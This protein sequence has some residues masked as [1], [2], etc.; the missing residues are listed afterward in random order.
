RVY[1]PGPA[2]I[3]CAGAKS[4]LGYTEAHG[5][6]DRAM[7][8]DVVQ[9]QA[10]HG[11]VTKILTRGLVRMRGRRLAVEPGWFEPGRPHFECGKPVAIALHRDVLMLPQGKQVLH[12]LRRSLAEAGDHAS[13][14]IEK[15]QLQRSVDDPEPVAYRKPRRGGTPAHFIHQDF[16]GSPGHSI[17]AGVLQIGQK[18]F[19]VAAGEL[20]Q[21]KDLLR[22]ECVDV[23][24]GIAGFEQT[25]QFEIPFERQIGIDAAL[26]ENVAAADSPDLLHL[27]ENF[28]ERESEG[29]LLM[30]GAIESAKPAG[31]DADIRIVN[32]A[33]NRVSGY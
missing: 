27:A 23:N 15:P 28:I 13:P 29:F 32:V 31:H 26:N 19:R 25:E 18:V 2:K 20:L 22:A 21:A 17:H 14:W 16:S 10:R 4:R 12:A 24:F 1:R 5:T 7:V 6:P 33:P 9:D 30:P 8:A 11:N 3:I